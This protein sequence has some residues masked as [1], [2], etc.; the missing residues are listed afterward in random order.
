MDDFI[1]YCRACGKQYAEEEAVGYSTL[2]G[3]C[4][5]LYY[6]FL[7]RKNGG[8]IALFLMCGMV[9][10]PCMPEY[11]TD[12]VM[13]GTGC[14][15][16]KYLAALREAG[17]LG[18]RGRAFKDGVTNIRQLFGRDMTETDFAKF[19]AAEQTREGS[20]KTGTEKQRAKW[21]TGD[22]WRGFPFT[23]DLYDALDQKYEERLQTYKG[24]TITPQMDNT[25]IRVV[26]LDA[27]IDYLMS[28]GD[29][30][31][32]LELQKTVDNLLAGEQMRKKDEKP[33]ETMRADA[34]VLALENAGMMENNAF[35][36]I[37]EMLDALQKGFFKKKKYDYSVDACDQMI[38][39]I[40]NNYRIN[41]GQEIAAVLPKEMKIKD[42]LGEFE[43][44]ETEEEKKRKH[45]LNLTPVS[46]EE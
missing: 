10:I 8:H 38:M 20:K 9:N 1:Y 26:K 43:K 37:P 42:E 2:C 44:K 27:C 12:S 19:I 15:W 16:E 31:T 46:F 29:S 40:Y 13:N 39:D 36:S 17:E 3:A 6:N 34:M 22:L 18:E 7:A 33:V 28:I 14:A 5:R 41:A 11:A 35:L 30:R 23:D 45:F 4:Q 24:M 32:I 21:G 25:L